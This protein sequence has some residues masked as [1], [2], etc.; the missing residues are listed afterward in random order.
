MLNAVKITPQTWL[1]LQA[2]AFFIEK[3]LGVG[4]FGTVY[5]VT[6][7]GYTFALKLNRFWELLPSDRD[8][9]RRRIKQEYDISHCLNSPNIVKTY[10]SEEIEGNP[11]FIMDFCANGNLKDRIGKEIGIENVYKYGIDI[12]RGLH[13]LHEFNII[14][15]DIKPENILFKQEKAMLSDF[16]ISAN[17]GKRLTERD[18]RGRAKQVFAS[19]SYA[20]PEQSLKNESFKSTG[21]TNDIF[22]FGVVMYE[23]ITKGVLPFGSIDD[24]QKDAE[25]FQQ[26]KTRGIWNER[27]LAK[28]ADKLWMHII[29]GCLNPNPK[30]RFQRVEEIL[31]LIPGGMPANIVRL[32]IQNGYQQ[33]MIFNLTNLAKNKN[34]RV[35][36]IGRYD[37]LNPFANDIFIQGEESEY[38][39]LNHATFE[40][41]IG[42]DNT[43]LWFIRDGQWCSKNGV[44]A[45]HPS[46]N[47][48][49]LNDESVTVSGFILQKGD[50]ITIGKTLIK[51]K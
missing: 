46:T 34:K 42:Q 12:L 35:L 23:L 41:T 17:L 29:K 14:H 22:S 25:K 24:F 32:E 9:I 27:K 30:K 18:L 50:V 47:G 3:E 4:G 33:G 40:M 45:W 19:F 51:V 21:P 2:G 11:V 38:V 28:H 16:G 5:K 20:P 36:T 7:D 48:L 43:P 15:R 13:D 8:E 44:Q 37:E 39:S 49:T 10:H 1:N 26:Y 31:E 6:K